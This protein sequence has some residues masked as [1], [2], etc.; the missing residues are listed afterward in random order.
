MAL[1][2]HQPV[3]KQALHERKKRER[4]EVRYQFWMPPEKAALIDRIAAHFECSRAEAVSRLVDA[5][6]QEVAA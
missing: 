1:S 3:T 2:D 6:L 5:Q 4:G